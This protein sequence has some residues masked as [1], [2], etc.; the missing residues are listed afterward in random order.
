[1]RTVG[2]MDPP[3]ALTRPLDPEQVYRRF[4]PGVLG[5]VRAQAASDPEDLA[6]EVFAQVVRDLPRFDGDDDELRRWV[7]TIAHHR[8]V[9]QHRR[10]RRRRGRLPV[11]ER[12]ERAVATP[13]DAVIGDVA[14]VGALQRLTRAQRD[15][16]VL[17][18]VADLPI[19]DVA[20][21]LHRRRGAV[22]ALQHRALATLSA[23]LAADD[24]VR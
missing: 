16:I 23:D 20:R 9:D 11:G 12:A 5:Y 3:G 10:R 13:D 17:R 2:Q 24:D 4:A 1:M 21:L 8:L 14:L 22:K 7:F 15:V 6:A 18:F 19:A